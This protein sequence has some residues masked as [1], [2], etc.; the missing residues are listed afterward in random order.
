M[1]SRWSSSLSVANNMPAHTATPTRAARNRDGGCGNA[2]ASRA[3]VVH[4]AYPVFTIVETAATPEA[5]PHP[6]RRC[7]ALPRFE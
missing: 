5:L 1:A 3:Q 2:D 4:A 6:A 7:G